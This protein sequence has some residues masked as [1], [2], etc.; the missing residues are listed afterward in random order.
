MTIN[1][2]QNSPSESSLGIFAEYP[3]TGEELSAKDQITKRR[4]KL[5]RRAAQLLPDERIA[6]CQLRV[7]PGHDHVAL[8]KNPKT[9]DVYYSHLVRC[10]SY[11]CPICAYWRSEQDRK[12]LSAALA[13]AQKKDLFPIL[14]TVTIRHNASHELGELREALGVATDRTFSGRW[15]QDLK[16]EWGVQCKISSWEVTYGKNGWHPHKHIL[17]FTDM[18]I[19]GKWVE[20]LNEHIAARWIEQL[21]KLGYDASWEHGVDVRTAD[22]DIADYIAKFGREPLDKAWGV[23]SELAK[24]PV[25]TAKLDGLTPFELLA[26]ADGDKATLERFSALVGWK[27]LNQIQRAAGWL[28]REYFHVFKGK[29]RIHWGATREILELDVFLEEMQAEEEAERVEPEIIAQIPRGEGWK[30]ISGYFAKEDLRAALVIVAR[31][32][33]GDDLREWFKK[34][35][36]AATVFLP[37]RPAPYP[38]NIPLQESFLHMVQKRHYQEV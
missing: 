10:E 29:A 19:V 25:K 4:F 26:A 5:L 38:E 35:D 3:S 23:D 20:K 22:S 14:V 12:E 32:G 24:T 28:Y 15:Y 7:A 17:F 13:Q 16:N 1:D 34:R 6:D 27:D 36:I 11:S 8:K 9:G 18:E 33:D 37:A 2:L 30:R 21:K 31:H